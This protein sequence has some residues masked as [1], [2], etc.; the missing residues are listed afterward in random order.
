M[1]FPPGRVRRLLK[2][3]LAHRVLELMGAEGPDGPTRQTETDAVKS[4]GS[5]LGEHDTSEAE[6]AGL[7]S[8]FARKSKPQKSGDG[9]S[10]MSPN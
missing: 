5:G 8:S 1:S 3:C 2:T 6:D 9:G 10:C 4:E 7:S